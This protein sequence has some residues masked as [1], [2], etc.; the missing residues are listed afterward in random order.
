MPGNDPWHCL[1]YG[2]GESGSTPA[3]PNFPVEHLGCCWDHWAEHP[4]MEPESLD[5]AQEAGDSG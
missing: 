3:L 2:N 4:S 1:N 5:N